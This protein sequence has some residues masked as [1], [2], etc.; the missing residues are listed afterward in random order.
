MPNLV[1]SKKVKLTPRRHKIVILDE[2]N[3]G[4][5]M[6]HYVLEG[7]EAIIFIADG[8]MRQIAC[9]Q[10]HPLHVK[11]MVHNM[12]EGNFDEACSGAIV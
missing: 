1:L 8:D 7:L 9:D 4:V 3:R 5:F 2:A 12:I 10:P 11:N 6:V